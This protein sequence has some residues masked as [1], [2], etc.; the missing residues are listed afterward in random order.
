MFKR[1]T[2][3]VKQE[4]INAQPKP[5]TGFQLAFS[6]LLDMLGQPNHSQRR[7]YDS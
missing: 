3:K 4:K 2:R 7:R 5:Q 6:A 1:P